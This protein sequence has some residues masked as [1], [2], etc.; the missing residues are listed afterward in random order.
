MPRRSLY[1]EKGVTARSRGKTSL[2][3]SWQ[4]DDAL[5]AARQNLQN[6]REL[7]YELLL[8]EKGLRPLGRCRCRAKCRTVSYN[9]QQALTL[10]ETVLLPPSCLRMVDL[11]H[12]QGIFFSNAD[13][14][15]WHSIEQKSQSYNK[16]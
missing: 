10:N 12:V 15:A 1:S 6:A 4:W 9:R 13:V 3:T 8:G 2:A 14:G 16:T 7:L 5:C 11:S